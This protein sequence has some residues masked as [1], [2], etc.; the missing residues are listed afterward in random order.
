MNIFSKKILILLF[1]ILSIEFLFSIVM[2]LFY[3]IESKTLI[4]SLVSFNFGMIIIG[5]VAYLFYI[6]PVIKINS[7][8]SERHNLKPGDLKDEISI[9]SPVIHRL[10]EILIENEQAT[11]FA[12][13]I[14]E[15]N[16]SSQY[17]GR[18]LES[19]L[20][21]VLINMRDK[22]KNVAEEEAKRNWTIKGLAKFDQL[23]R[24]NLNTDS[25]ELIQLLITDLSKYINAHIGA[26][27]IIND[28]TEETPF[29][30]LVSM[31]AYDR[32]KYITKRIEI[33]E[34]LI[35]QCVVEKDTLFITD[36]PNDYVQIKSGLGNSAPQSIVILPVIFNETVLGVIELASF[37]LFD[38]H[39]IDFL[40][41]VASN[42]GAAYS[43]I[44][45]NN[46]MS[47]LLLHANRATAELKEKEDHLLENEI[48]LRN[49]QD[50]LNIKLIELMAETNLTKSILDAI[51]KSNACIQYDMQGNILDA[52][53]MFISVMGYS[54]D[55][56]IGENE[57]IFIPDDELH[58][59][60][61]H[62]LWQSL[63]DGQ[64]NAGEFRRKAKNGKEV[65][66]DVTYNPILD[67]E[68][69]PFKILM[70]A[71]F[72]TVQ[73]EKEN[74]Y[75]NKI[76]AINEA[77][78]FLEI[79]KDFSIK[80]SNQFF[81]EKLKLKRKDLKS[82]TFI[83]M[84]K[85]ANNHD[86]EMENII[87]TINNGQSYSGKLYLQSSESKQ[88]PFYSILSAG[89]DL[90]GNISCYYAVMSYL[91]DLELNVT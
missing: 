80:S 79:N 76:N 66:M 38:T 42:F 89:H 18:N 26:I 60:R 46:V 72:T 14:G 63:K 8:I 45:A 24:E 85:D 83:E 74:E 12:Q 37:K 47:K 78:A 51:N 65:W 69:K 61:Y 53:D 39:E 91:G 40:K 7:I 52:N 22:L 43:S 33:G 68:G 11:H 44:K 9:Y 19:G 59:D 5:F 31:Y 90:N 10:N 70:F 71:N 2:K 84:L 28:E 54:K 23:F 48:E 88:L 16:F 29:I 13:L 87:S 30:E 67:L 49:A 27:Y 64:F 50:E 20:G 6:K 3:I 57:I 21:S 55:E 25:K 62:M 34:G 41:E 77:L 4:A 75:R 15:G 1:S 73:K 82:K 36:I 81:L 86:F 58:N 17:L 35:G 32:K 56:L